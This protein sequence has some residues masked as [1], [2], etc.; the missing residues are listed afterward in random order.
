MFVSPLS[1]SYLTAG[2]WSNT[3]PA[4][5]YVACADGQILVWD[6]TDSSFRPSIELKATH[7]KITSLELLNSNMQSSRLQMMAVGDESGTLHIF[8]MP[9]NLIKPVHKEEYV[10]QKFLERELQRNDL[11]EEMHQNAEL[12]GSPHKSSTAD[13]HD[14]GHGHGA[15]PG[16]AGHDVRASTAGD[17]NFGSV[18]ATAGTNRAG[19]AQLNATG[20]APLDPIELEQQA[21]AKEE[22]E[23]LKLESIFISE[24]GLDLSSL[25]SFA[26]SNI[27]TGAATVT[28]TNTSSK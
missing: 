9:R 12:P 20:T 26:A 2:C 18:P 22:D 24:L 8:E 16:T 11:A 23:F 10:M 13:G 15:P 17:D 7:S 5:L 28:S 27:A 4:V 19:T 1:N 14:H 25:P 3:R 21:I 6:F